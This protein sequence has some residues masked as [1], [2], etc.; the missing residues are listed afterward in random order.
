MVMKKLS[1]KVKKKQT[2]MLDELFPDALLHI[3]SFLD[4]HN[5][6]A[7]SLS[8]KYIF[9]QLYSK[10]LVNVCKMENLR[11]AEFKQAPHKTITRIGSNGVL[12][13][14]CEFCRS[15]GLLYSTALMFPYN[16]SV[17]KYICLE[18]CKTNC[19]LC[20]ISILT[21]STNGWFGPIMCDTC[22]SF[23]QHL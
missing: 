5:K 9:N 4:D 7:V 18:N 15:N 22:Y 14:E 10:T 13:G 23:R 8:C 2:I 19:I 16:R 6:L 17:D 1:I 20:N 12:R 3:A 11:L 21:H